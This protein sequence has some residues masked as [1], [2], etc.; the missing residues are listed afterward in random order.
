MTRRAAHTARRERRFRWVAVAGLL[1]LAAAAYLAFARQLPFGHSF[2]VSAVFHSA[3]NLEPGNPV[4]IAGLDI[5]HVTAVAARHDGTA[6]VTMTIDSAADRLH[7]DAQLAIVP[8]L[9]FEGNFYVSV[10]PGSPGAPPLRD[11]ATVA[12]GQTS[13]PVQIDQLLDVLTQPVR[14]ALQSTFTGL[15]SGLGGPRSTAGEAA[16]QRATAELDASLVNVSRTA[17]AL[18]GTAPSDLPDAIRSTGQVTSE[19]AEDP[20]ALAGI[21]TDY[22]RVFATLSA[23]DRDFSG[24]LTSLA[25]LERDATPKLRTIDDALPVVDRLAAE[26]RPSL[27]VLP[28]A[29]VSGTHAFAQING[30]SGANEL[31][32]TLRLLAPVTTNLPSLLNGLTRISTL[33]NAFGECITTHVLPVLDSTLKDGPNTTHVPVWQDLVHAGTALAGGSPNFDGNGTTIRLGVTESELALTNS[34]P[35]IGQIEGASGIEGVRPVPLAPG[36]VP[37]FR[38]DASCLSQALPDLSARSGGPPLADMRA[39]PQVAPS[40]LLAR[41]AAMLLGSPAERARL[42]G[43]LLAGLSGTRNSPQPG[44]TRRPTARSH[45]APSQPVPTASSPAWHPTPKPGGT[46][47]PPALPPVTSGVNKLLGSL[48]GHLTANLGSGRR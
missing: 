23:H 35:G 13:S 20:S 17:R 19:L 4:R 45:S 12:L 1:L 34:V 25:S 22:A 29:L 41:D 33:G 37:P 24:D 36:V 44:A 31:P 21:V 26:L 2:T 46:V 39:I 9:A 5:G 16:L 8:R 40:P 3:D 18:Q 6:R 14:A 7:A 10:A 30:I 32:L 48:V 43:E 15:A 11:G 38:P 42:L 47:T 28:A 27:T